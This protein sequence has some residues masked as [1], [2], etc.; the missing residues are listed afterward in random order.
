MIPLAHIQQWTGS[1]PWADLRQVE[2]DLIISRVLCD[3]FASESLHGRIAF[4][5]GT[6]IHKL[7]LDTPLR[8]SEDIDLVQTRAEPI[9]EIIDGVRAA[10]PWLGRC[11]RTQ[12]RH[13]MQLV[14]RFSPETG[15]GEPLKIKIEINTREHQSLYGLREYPFSLNSDWHQASVAIASFDPSEV[16]GTKLRAFLQRNKNRD[17]FD[18]HEGLRLPALDRGRLLECFQ[19]CMELEGRTIS[20][21]NAEERML[22]KLT[23][24]LTEDVVPLL[25]PGVVFDD[26][27]A[28]VAFGR[29]WNELVTHLPGEAWKSSQAVV[30]TIRATTIPGLFDGFDWQRPA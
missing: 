16:F 18:L 17:L 11:S 9:G 24:S 10:L 27:T 28:V 5:G 6:A 19:H 20:R 8:Y 4:R 26:A 14:F 29:V 1:A 3:L 2:Q 25:P 7:L 12:A 30:E 13:S 21:A 23:Q 22:Q 15:S